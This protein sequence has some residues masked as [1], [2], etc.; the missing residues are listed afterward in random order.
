M[1][2]CFIKSENSLTFPWRSEPPWPFAKACPP[3]GHRLVSGGFRQAPGRL[4]AHAA[5]MGTGTEVAFRG[6]R[7]AAESGRTTSGSASRTGGLTVPVT[8]FRAARQTT[9]GWLA[10][11]RPNCLDGPLEAQ[12]GTCRCDSSPR[13]KRTPDVLTQPGPR[14]VLPQKY[15]QADEPNRIWCSLNY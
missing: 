13:P 2:V 15:A 5:R 14:S 10:Y 9:H 8:P 7:H 1:P 6:C 11:L 4:D 3:R 12:C